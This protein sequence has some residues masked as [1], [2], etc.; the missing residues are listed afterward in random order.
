VLTPRSGA[1]RLACSE[2]ARPA[3]AG[4]ASPCSRVR[5]GDRPAVGRGRRSHSPSLLHRHYYTGITVAPGPDHFPSEIWS[6]SATGS[7]RSE[8]W[9]A[10]NGKD[11]ASGTTITW[12]HPVVGLPSVRAAVGLALARGVP[13]RALRAGQNHQK[14]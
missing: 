14:Y 13:D 7:Y 1:D 2:G 11:T 5:R 8:Y 12:V 9:A 4:R 6:C 10:S 3:T